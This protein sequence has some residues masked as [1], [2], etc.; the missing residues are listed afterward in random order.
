MNAVAGPLL[1]ASPVRR[2]PLFLATAL[3]LTLPAAALAQGQPPAPPTREDLTV[4]RDDTPDR[5]SRL[6]V[7]GDIERGPCPLADPAFANTRVTFSTV[8]F[9]GLPGVPASVLEPAWRDLAGRDMPVAALC[10]VRDRAA[11]ILR[12]LGYLAAVQ[13]PPQRID[14]GGTVRMDVLAAQ[15]IENGCTRQL[16]LLSTA[17]LIAEG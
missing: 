16:E 13:V 7:E 11:S 8:E 5:A 1:P 2:Y 4:G 14:A 17:T 3:A 15:L 10:D 12:G 9:T 6:S